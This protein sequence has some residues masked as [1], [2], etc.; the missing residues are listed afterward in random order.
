VLECAAIGMPDA[1]V[2]ESVKVIVVKRDPAVTEQDIRTHCEAN[3]TGYKRPKVVEF[4]A[5]LPKT[6]S[7]RSCA[8]NCVTPPEP[9]T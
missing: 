9:L 7:A 4:R 2:G 3:L 5:E 1:L 6:R 8:V